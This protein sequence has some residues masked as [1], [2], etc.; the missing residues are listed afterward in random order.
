MFSLRLIYFSLSLSILFDSFH[1]DASGEEIKREFDEL[2]PVIV[3]IFDGMNKG[4]MHESIRDWLGGDMPGVLDGLPGPNAHPQKEQ[5]I[6]PNRL[7]VRVAVQ[8]WWYYCL[9]NGSGNQE[10]TGRGWGRESTRASTVGGGDM[11][12]GE[13]AEDESLTQPS[14]MH[15]HMVP[16]LKR[17]NHRKHN[18]HH[19]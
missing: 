12:T 3:P 14:Y 1:N 7:E 16:I 17:T 4:Q 15:F 19:W 9:S 13:P 10:G 5:Q 11:E 8:Q 2:E 6:N 18:S